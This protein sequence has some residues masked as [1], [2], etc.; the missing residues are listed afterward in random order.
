M[1]RLALALVCLAA[2]LTG[3]PPADQTPPETPAGVK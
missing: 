3:C 2:L 1:K